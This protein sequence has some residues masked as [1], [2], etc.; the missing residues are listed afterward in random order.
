MIKKTCKGCYAAE[1][2]S[3]PRVGQPY[4]CLLAYQTDGQGHPA[5]EC[6]KPKSWKQLKQIE[7]ERRTN[8]E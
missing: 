1:T 5:E 8:H 6:P 2:G 4:G 7:K 3:H